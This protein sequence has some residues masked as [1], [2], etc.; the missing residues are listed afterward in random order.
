MRT[1][2]YSPHAGK[3]NYRPEDDSPEE[4][5]S[6][7]DDEYVPDEVISTLREKV[8]HVVDLSAR[9]YIS[10]IRER[11]R[12]LPCLV[13]EIKQ[14]DDEADQMHHIPRRFIKAMCRSM[15][16][17]IEHLHMAGG[18]ALQDEQFLD[19]TLR[20]DFFVAYILSHM[21]P[22]LRNMSWA[23]ASTKTQ[24]RRRTK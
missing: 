7:S 21:I 2:V 3:R 13:G 16:E 17:S 10:S 4:E 15:R 20:N 19:A 9:A 24:K 18:A 5:Q 12:D 11:M 14:W 23:P 8:G 1:Q 6:S 22:T